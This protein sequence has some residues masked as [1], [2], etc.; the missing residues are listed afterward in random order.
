MTPESPLACP[1]NNLDCVQCKD[2]DAHSHELQSRKS[3]SDEDQSRIKEILSQRTAAQQVP[4][5]FHSI[6]H[7]VTI[8]PNL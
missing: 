1:S 4:A 5:M 6:L 8:L 3:L 7:V 2:C